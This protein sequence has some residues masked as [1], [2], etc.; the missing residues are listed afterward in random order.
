MKALS[1][2]DAAFLFLERKHMPMHVGGVY[3][4]SYPKGEN[5]EWLSNLLSTD[6][7][8]IQAPFNQKL[9]W[10]KS[11]LGAPYWE[12]DRDLDVE[13][14]VRHSALPQPGRYREMFS[15][16]SRLHSTPLHRDRPL[17]EAHIIEGVEENRFA[18]YSKMHHSLIDGMAGM[19]LLQAAL[20]TDPDQRGMQPPWANQRKRKPRMSEPKPSQIK[21]VSGLLQQQL[22]AIP[23]AA[24]GLKAFINGVRSKAPHG[25]VA[26]F[27]APKTSLNGEIS[28]SRRFVAQSYS[29]SRIKN[30]GNK[31]GVTVNDMVLAMS[32][33]ALR[34]YLMQHA[35]LP[36]DPL[37]A[38]APVSIRSE[39]G[40]DLGNAVSAILVSL[41][42]NIAD[43]FQRLH[44]IQ[45]SVKASKDIL[46]GM[47]ATE[48][49]LYTAVV[50]SPMGI[51]MIMGMG[52]KLPPPFNLTIS[53]VPG[54]RQKMYW[55]GAPLEGMY[56]VS[57]V[58][59][60]GA[61]NVTV[62]SYEDS[63]DFGIIA[64]RKAVPSAQ[65]LIDYLE[66]ALK[67]LE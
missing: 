10:R 39:G 4:F 62:T 32:A 14:H 45:N 56:P 52:G 59:E 3:L 18:L 19:R 36:D 25:L 54:P 38:M 2:T 8:D 49:L 30:I 66:D 1:P 31:L 55:N 53:N 26:P 28:A 27:Q 43:P 67:E 24:N 15:L 16:V 7:R 20:S 40:P 65:R 11:R 64:C 60:G 6:A 50:S 22:G 48:T 29:L 41:A 21:A 63:L 34:K 9:R 5:E 12:E 58:F 13:Y 57:I 37:I 47:D 17:W 61:V 46:K 51:P 35:E 23:G 42:T 44:A 33:S